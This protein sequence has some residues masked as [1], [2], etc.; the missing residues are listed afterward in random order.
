MGRR[1]DINS[2]RSERREGKEGEGR[3]NES[4]HQEDPSYSGI[5]PFLLVYETRKFTVI[6]YHISLSA[7]LTRIVSPATRINYIF[8]KSDT[9]SAS[10]YGGN[11]AKTRPTANHRRSART[12]CLMGQCAESFTSVQN[13]LKLKFSMLLP[14]KG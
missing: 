11:I 12:F 13:H 9:R 1:V 8:Q 3:L 10:I 2:E 4:L 7:R 5:Y 6:N 14:L